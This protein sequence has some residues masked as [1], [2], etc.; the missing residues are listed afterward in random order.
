MKDAVII[1]IGSQE[2]HGPHLPPNTDYLIAK[3]VSK[4]ISEYFSIQLDNG[5]LIS[6]SPEHIGFKETQSISRKDFISQVKNKLSFYGGKKYKLLINAHGGNTKI[7]KDLENEG[8]N[9]F[10][11]FDIFTVM[12]KYFKLIRT[13]DIGGICHA[14]EFETSLMLYLY[15][16]KVQFNKLKREY[17]KYVPQLD[18][19]YMGDRIK[20][21]KTIELNVHGILGDPLKATR[22]KGRI[23]FEYLTQNIISNLKMRLKK[24][25]ENFL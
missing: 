7:L 13:S 18:P 9:K 10:I 23:W 21:W 20:N 15:P 17:I 12:K 5:I 22:E 6:H 14:G 8:N 2:Q 4:E 25:K 1:P 24:N 16:E 19:E 3:S 11:L